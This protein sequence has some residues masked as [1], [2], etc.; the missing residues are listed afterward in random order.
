MARQA[1]R[2]QPDFIISTGDNFYD[3]GVLSV[4]DPLWKTAFEDVYHHEALQLPWFCVLGNHDYGGDTAAQ[5]R[6]SRISGRWHM[7]GRYFNHKLQNGSLSAD[8]IFSDTTPLIEEYRQSE[9]HPDVIFQNPDRQL[10]WLRRQLAESNA[11]WKIV[12]GH[13]PVYSSSP[14]H[15][16]TEELLQAYLPL[17]RTYE[18]DA[19]LCGHEH[20][21]QLQK[22]EGET[23][24]V[25]SGAGSEVREAGRKEMTAFSAS[26]GGFASISLCREA[27][28]I[29]FFA[30]D[31]QLLYEA[32]KARSLRPSV[33]S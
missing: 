33:G 31:G 15:G 18:A 6:Y 4:D 30:H 2:L 19:Y 1:S 32:S 8:F 12:I 16:D 21:L 7:P 25:I 28:T 13:H 17:F 3:E 29:S 23:F 27:M 20:D 10:N 9:S 14:M 24:Y 11:N 5:L 22:P 26:S